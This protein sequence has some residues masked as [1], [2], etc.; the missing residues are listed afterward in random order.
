[1]KKLLLLIALMATIQT[2]ASE[3]N[4]T[5]LSEAL[6]HCQEEVYFQHAGSVSEREL[7]DMIQECE[8]DT[9]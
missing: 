2:K 9:E 6:I 4:S 8:T 1:M 5:R 7:L 3:E